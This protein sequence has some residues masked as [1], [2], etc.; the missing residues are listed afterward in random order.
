MHL[1]S[2]FSAIVGD[3]F[4][5]EIE[6]VLRRIKNTRNKLAQ[7]GRHDT[8]FKSELELFIAAYSLEMMLYCLLL[9][10]LGVKEEMKDK[11]VKNGYE[12]VQAMA[13]INNFKGL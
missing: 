5:S 4:N 12:N 9:L 13:Q 6:E 1:K 3:V 7:E 8:E 2:E 10:R 11:L